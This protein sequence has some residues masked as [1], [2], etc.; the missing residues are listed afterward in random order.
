MKTVRCPAHKNGRRVVCI[1][2]E[3]GEHT[4]KKVHAAVWKMDAVFSNAQ[5]TEKKLP[6]QKKNHQPDW[7]FMPDIPVCDSAVDISFKLKHKKEKY[8]SDCKQ[9]AADNECRY[10]GICRG[11]F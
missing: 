1:A 9:D 4:V 6:C 8:S 5:K 11:I 3:Y 10:A 2:D 7:Q